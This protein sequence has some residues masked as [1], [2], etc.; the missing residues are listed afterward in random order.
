MNL[1]RLAIVP[2]GAPDTP[3]LDCGKCQVEHGTPGEG[4]ATYSKVG[5]AMTTSTRSPVSFR[6]PI[7]ISQGKH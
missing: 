4:R 1:Q 3:M 2:L 6:T 5:D 7:W